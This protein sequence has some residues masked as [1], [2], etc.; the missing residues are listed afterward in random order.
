MCQNPKLC[1]KI[2][3]TVVGAAVIIYCVIKM[4]MTLEEMP[5]DPTYRLN[6]VI[7]VTT[8]AAI[9]LAMLGMWVF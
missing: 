9:F 1:G 5:K 6:E 4:P 8:V 3:G 7:C 2:L